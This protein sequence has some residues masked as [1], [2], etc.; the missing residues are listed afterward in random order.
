MSQ[1]NEWERVLQGIALVL[2]INIVLYILIGFFIIPYTID[3]LIQSG[4][5]KRLDR[6]RS[7]DATH[8]EGRQALFLGFNSIFVYQFI[9]IIPIVFWLKHKQRY[10][11][12]KGVIIGATITALLSGVCF[13]LF[14]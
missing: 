8:I 13:L 9:Y 7:I 6:L 4:L 14:L 1:R 10:G 11:L 2:V 12:M 5:I 3:P